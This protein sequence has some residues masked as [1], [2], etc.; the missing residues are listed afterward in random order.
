MVFSAFGTVTKG[1]IKGLRNQRTIRDHPNNSIVEIGQ[2][3]KMCPGN[4]RRFA[5][6][7][8]SMKNHQLTLP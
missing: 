1:L 4:L 6:I 8:T 5:V 7:Q 3:T 2:N